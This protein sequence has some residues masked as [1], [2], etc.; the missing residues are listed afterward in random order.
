MISKPPLVSVITPS[1]NQVK[2]LEQTMKSVLYQ[3]YPYIE[4]LVV[5]GGSTDGSVEIIRKYNDRINWWV[6][7]K[8][9]G[10][11]EGINKGLKRASGK[12]IAWLNSDDLYYQPG[13]VSEAVAHLESGPELGM[14]YADGV[15]VDA[16]G[17]LLDWHRYRQ[18]NLVDLLSFNV[19]LQPTVFIRRTVLLDVGYL[20]PTYRL[21]LDHEL[22]VRIAKKYPISH[23]NSFWAV[24]RTHEHA[25][26]ISSAAGF[27]EEANLLIRSQMDDPVVGSI[28]LEKQ[29]KIFSGLHV[30]SGRRL[31]DAGLYGEAL[32]HFKEAW[33]YSPS[34]VLQVWYKII[35]ATGGTLGLSRIFLKYRASRRRLQHA[36][37]R[38][39][40]KSN[41]IQWIT[42]EEN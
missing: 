21:I 13:V 35:Q 27:V 17:Y 36:R 24:E 42:D 37:K 2:Y 6:S 20:D 3:D 23:V 26:T 1:Y 14:V 30:F 4:F 8:D 25:K 29:P 38:I 11:S 33:K 31:I 39:Q 16:E 19:I 22:W 9:Y 34:A 18:L 28:L 41:G 32:Y 10:Q 15:M 5:D 7:E 12:Y 40:L